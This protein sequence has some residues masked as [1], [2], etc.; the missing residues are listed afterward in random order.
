M[1]TVKSGI[2]VM[3]EGMINATTPQDCFVFFDDFLSCSWAVIS[4]GTDEAMKW[5]ATVVAQAATGLDI[6]S[7]KDDTPALTGGILSITTE[8]TDNDGEN[9][10]S[11]GEAFGFYTGQW[12]YLESRFRVIDADATDVFIGLSIIDAEILSGGVDDKMGFL[13]K[14]NVLSS[15]CEKSGNELSNDLK[16]TEADTLW[17]RVAMFYDGG[18]KVYFFVDDTDNGVFQLKDTREISTVADYICDD[19]NLTPTI[20]V[21]NDGGAVEVVYIDY[22]YCAQ[23]RYSS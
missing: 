18:D 12:L 2:P 20:E 4:N 6:L 8:A 1:P 17:M 16:I 19:M 22:Y 5:K 3:V 15:N 14:D 23:Q 11:H 21:I 10:Q 7:G 13:H 9:L